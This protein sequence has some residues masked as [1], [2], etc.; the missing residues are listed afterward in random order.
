MLAVESAS[1][2]WP[3]LD[4][5]SVDDGLAGG[6]GTYVRDGRIFAA[7]CGAVELRGGVVSVAAPNR[8]AMRVGAEVIAR[9]HR[10]VASNAVLD[11]VAVDGAVVDF[12]AQGSLR[13][14]DAAA[15]LQAGT[16]DVVLL[17]LAREL[18]AGDL[19]RAR[20]ISVAD[21]QRYA[22]SVAEP[23][24]GRLQRAEPDDGDDR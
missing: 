15:P 5:A 14:E 3:G 8:S 11:I 2:V 12:P 7:L 17:D 18:R 19:V 4:L 24:H 16:D 21:A 22:L 10:V 23:H 9:V 6:H 1:V 20:I 13:R